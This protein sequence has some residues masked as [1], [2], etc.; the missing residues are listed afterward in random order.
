MKI[1]MKRILVTVAL[2]CMAICSY[3][4]RDIPAGGCMDVA[5]VETSNSIGDNVGFGKQV[6]LYKVKDNEGN[7]SFL[8]SI[9]GVSLSLSVG[10]DISS[11]TL[12]IP[13]GGVLLDFGTTYQEAMDNL[14]AL[15]DMF[16]EKDGTQ[17]ELIC[18]DGS[19]VQCTLNKGF[20]GKH[21]DIAETSLTKSNVKSLKTSFKISKKLH[22]DL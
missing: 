9:S 3:A 12:S 10:T 21:L 7:P 1:A 11:S 19:K 4:Q 20:L 8:L 5:S 22:P 15:I 13:T 6:T 17:K 14:D 18:R 2:M 16:A